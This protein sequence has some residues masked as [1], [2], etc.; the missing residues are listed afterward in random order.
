M[1]SPFFIQPAGEGL[2]EGL[3]GLGMILRA[4]KER[5]E[6]RAAAAEKEERQ[7][8]MMGAMWD[9]SQ[10]KD[11]QAW[12]TFVDEYP[13][14]AQFA[15]QQMGVLEDWQK[16]EMARD[17]LAVLSNPDGALDILD[18]RIA[19]GGPNRDMSHSQELRE[20]LASGDKAGAFREAQAAL[21]WADND[22]WKAWRESRPETADVPAAMQTLQMRAAAA[23]LVE[24]TPEYQEFMRTG[25]SPARSLASA[26]TRTYDNGTVLQSLPD[27]S[28]VVLGPDGEQLTGEARVQALRKAREEEVAFAGARAAAT[29]EGRG[30]QNRLQKTIDEGLDAAQGVP[31]LRRALAL[32]DEVKTGGFN[33]AAIRARQMFGIE[34]ADEGE[35]SSN[36]GKAVLS[37]LR[38]TFGAAFTEREGARLEGIEAR[39]GASTEANKRLLQQT[40]AIVERAANR[41]IDAAYESG[42]D[43]TAQDIEGLLDFTL[44]DEGGQQGGTQVGRFL[45]TPVE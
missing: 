6:E 15:L 38:A 16:Q 34:S 18:K 12:S 26:V 8:A 35:L 44:T 42:D 23:G 20:L 5:E 14:G 11:P 43:R 32:L 10:K 9:A 2:G 45:V 27:G 28:T 40:L 13:E 31:V 41:A 17:A 4:N 7:R 19:L 3:A 33:A 1:V 24:G 22:A 36:L 30:E 39:L 25:G 29:A 21:I 37:Q